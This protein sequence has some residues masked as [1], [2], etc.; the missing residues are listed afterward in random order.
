MLIYLNIKT[1]NRLVLT[2]KG[3]IYKEEER[4]R[5]ETQSYLETMKFVFLLLGELVTSKG[6]WEA[7]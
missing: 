4:G 2:N 7:D 5:E 6:P 3:L 1:K